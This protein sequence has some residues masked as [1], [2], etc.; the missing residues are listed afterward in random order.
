M[1]KHFVLD[2]NVLLHDPLAMFHFADNVVVIPI[3]VL[4]EIDQF[5]KELSERGRNARELCRRL[6]EFRNSGHHLSEG[7]DLPGGGQL[8]V[9]LG[10]REV[11]SA[12][13][14]SQVADNLILG[15]AL[16]VRD[17]DPGTQ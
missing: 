1:R 4:E 17:T 5:K 6:D 15:V 11:P 9:A 8:R 14:T 10:G 2:T 3:Y 7:V 12:L 13:R 16:Q